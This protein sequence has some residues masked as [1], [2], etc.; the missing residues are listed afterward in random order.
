MSKWR[1]DYTLR[2]DPAVRM[3]KKMGKSQRKKSKGRVQ[4]GKEAYN[5]NLKSYHRKM[6]DMVKKGSSLGDAMKAMSKQAASRK[7]GKATSRTAGKAHKN[8]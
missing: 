5:N 4:A 6:M 2:L 3:N 8:P 7:K 1:F